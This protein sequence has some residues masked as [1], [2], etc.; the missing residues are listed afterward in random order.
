MNGIKGGMAAA[1]LL[2]AAG[3]SLPVKAQ[4]GG[5]ERYGS[6]HEMPT[7]DVIRPASRGAAAAAEDLRLKGKCDKA[8][9][10]LRNIVD[11]DGSEISQFNL[12]LCLLELAGAEHDAQKA[13]D[14]A[15]EGAE[16]M[17]R[18]ANAGF[19]RA[20]ARAVNLYLD[21]TGVAAD[22]VEAEKWAL[23]YH[24]NPLRFSIAL[25]DIAADVSDRLNAALTGAK[26]AEA[27]ARA[28]A[29]TKTASATDE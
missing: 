28:N 22:P 23:L 9:P 4:H 20:Q 29:W 2:V 3:L 25:P 21:G 17:L 10:L 13:A 24:A 7:P 27:R 15:K 12:G 18:S 26:R 6:P 19:A 8:V 5:E 1:V 11:R 14:Q 16:W